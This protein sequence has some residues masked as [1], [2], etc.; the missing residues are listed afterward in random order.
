MI[1]PPLVFLTAAVLAWL[2]NELELIPWRRA[3]GAHWTERARKLFPARISQRI[4]LW[5]VP[6]G[7]A[8][9]GHVWFPDVPWQLVL[10]AGILG[11]LLASFPMDR[12]L[13]PGLKFRAWLEQVATSSLL[14]YPAWIL[15]VV[16]AVAMPPRFGWPVW[17]IA[18]VFLVLHF[19]LQF[20]LGLR[21]MR[22]L[23]LLRPASPRLQSLVDETCA[24]MG[25]KVN[26]T[27]ELPWAH[28]NAA[29]MVTTRELV[30][31]E[32]MLAVCPDDEVRAI[33]A[34]ELGHLSESR[35]VLGGRIAGTLQLF[36][37]IFIRPV[38]AWFPLGVAYLLIAFLVILALSLRLAR[39]ME[40]RADQ[41]AREG[42]EEATVYARALERLYMTS[43]IPAVQ[44]KSSVLTHPDL[45]DRMVA[46]GLTPDYPRPA[47]PAKQ[48]WTSLVMTVACT[49]LAMYLF[50]D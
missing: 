35:W 43:R 42:I 39:T 17:V 47:A 28:A 14:M 3:S 20:G 12:E 44:R 11:A 32:K 15:L 45:Y 18:G 37:L 6:A 27:W 4:N 49:L 48:G 5:V 22:R 10:A 29:A 13:E 36:P 23:G 7:L 38:N 41:V 50:W 30:F 33:C 34:H 26:A 19:A 46:A 9:L 8:L 16:T 31:A 40:K 1:L 2:C 24:R 21:L 25:I